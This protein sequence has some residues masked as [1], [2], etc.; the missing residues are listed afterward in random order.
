MSSRRIGGIHNSGIV[1]L[2][3]EPLG[4][5]ALACMGRMTSGGDS[6]NMTAKTC[7]PIEAK[8]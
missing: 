7:Q 1:A 3:E 6:Q 5:V 2:L 8:G 4:V